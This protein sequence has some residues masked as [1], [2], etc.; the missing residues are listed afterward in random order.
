MDRNLFVRDGELCWSAS[1]PD[2]ATTQALGRALGEACTGGEVVLLIGS[3]GAGKTCL[4]Q[5]LA[6]GLG[7]PDTVRVTSPTFTLHSRY[8]GRCVL[9]HMDLYRL[10]GGVHLHE[11]GLD[12]HLGLAPHVTAIEW[13]DLLADTIPG[14]I[15]IVFD[16]AVTPR[17]CVFTAADPDAA[18][19][20]ARL[21]TAL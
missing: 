11:L 10:E 9:D 8:T 2:A 21:E 15:E 7:I 6:R 1:L 18:A 17:R 3:L 5:G 16:T 12:E 20:F 19:V 4:V 13:A 14:A